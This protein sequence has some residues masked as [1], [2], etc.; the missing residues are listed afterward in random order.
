MLRWTTMS[1]GSRA[2]DLVGGTR[3]SAQP[4]HK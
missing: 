4:I 3:L 1:P 2:D